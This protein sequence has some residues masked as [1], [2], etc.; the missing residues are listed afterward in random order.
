ML[1]G[2]IDGRRDI[3]RDGAKDIVPASLFRFEVLI[4]LYRNGSLRNIGIV[5]Q[6]I[7]IGTF[8]TKK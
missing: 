4:L 3:C 7:L 6:Q 8:K 5:C 2:W 1:D